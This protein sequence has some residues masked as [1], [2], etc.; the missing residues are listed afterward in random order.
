[1]L[2]AARAV[3]LVDVRNGRDPG[4]IRSI[5]S[6]ARFDRYE[7][8]RMSNSGG[9]RRY[10]DQGY[11]QPYEENYEENYS[12]RGNNYQ[13]GNGNRG[14]RGNG[15]YRGGTQSD[16]GTGGKK[17]ID[18]VFSLTLYSMIVRREELN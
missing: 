6:V 3:M 16:A 11:Q 17:A 5:V 8:D 15:S 2:M 7:N 12:R 13:T 1:M 9:G 10:R 4:G 18:S 14:R